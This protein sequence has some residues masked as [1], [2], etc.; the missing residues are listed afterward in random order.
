MGKEL[1][2]ET[3]GFG[4]CRLAGNAHTYPGRIS[5]WSETLGTWV[6]I[7]RSDVREAPP[8]AWVWI[9]SYLAGNEPAFHS[10][11]GIEPYEVTELELKGEE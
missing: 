10:F 3:D 2:V 4:R 5:A 1:W 9:D 6:T 8:D 7:S 11:L